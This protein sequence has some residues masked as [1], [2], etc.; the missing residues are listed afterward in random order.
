MISDNTAKQL[1]DKSTRGKPL[2]NE[3]Q[4]LLEEW[5]ALQDKKE[6]DVL[7]NAN[8]DTRLTDL[9]T[10]VDTA[11]SQ[12]TATTKQV[13]EITKENEALK[14]ESIKLRRQYIQQLSFS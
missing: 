5:Y 11:L 3:E 9:R 12:L 14:R 7:L 6:N 1:H 13:Q 4:S 10:Q 8:N 2:T